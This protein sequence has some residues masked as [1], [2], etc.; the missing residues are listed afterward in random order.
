MDVDGSTS[1]NEDPNRLKRALPE[2][3]NF[4]GV[5]ELRMMLK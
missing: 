5:T 4:L 2:L 3:G 1:P